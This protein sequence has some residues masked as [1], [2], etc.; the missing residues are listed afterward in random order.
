MKAVDRDP[1]F[2][3]P[4]Y[5][6]F[7]LSTGYV[8]AELSPNEWYTTSGNIINSPYNP[9]GNYLQ[10]PMYRGFGP[11]SETYIIELDKARDF[12]SFQPGGAMMN[13]EQG[14]FITPWYPKIFDGDIIAEVVRDN[15]GN[16]LSVGQVWEAKKVIPLTMRGRDRLG[17]LET[18]NPPNYGY[19]NTANRFIIQQQFDTA[20]VPA[21]DIRVTGGQWDR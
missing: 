11:S 2:G 10:A 9:G 16:V 21:L 4:R 13:V 14:G 7:S 3:Q 5:A 1:N 8:S 12:F 18:P 6:S 20:L 19:Q 15:G 17:N